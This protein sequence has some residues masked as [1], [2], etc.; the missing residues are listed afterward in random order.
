LA[1]EIIT[2]RLPDGAGKAAPEAGTPAATPRKSSAPAAAA[3]PKIEFMKKFRR[4]Q[5]LIKNF[6]RFT[7]RW[8][9][10]V[11]RNYSSPGGERK[12]GFSQKRFCGVGV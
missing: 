4:D 6:L 3:L 7:S 8:L 2:G 11:R 12:H 10:G 5:R 9:A 1:L